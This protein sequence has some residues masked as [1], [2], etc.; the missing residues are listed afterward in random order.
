MIALYE[1]EGHVPPPCPNSSYHW[2]DIGENRLYSGSLHKI[3]FRRLCYKFHGFYGMIVS[4]VV[5][6]HFVKKSICVKQ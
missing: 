5:L 1:D 6:L 2:V 3:W 4:L